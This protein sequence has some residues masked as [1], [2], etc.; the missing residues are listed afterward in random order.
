MPSPG[1][2]AAT[3]R[4]GRRHETRRPRQALS[5]AA[6]APTLRRRPPRAGG[7]RKHPA[8]ACRDEHVVLDAH[9]DPAELR[10]D[11]LVVGL[12]VQ[13]GLDRQHHALGQRTPLIRLGASVG[14]VVHVQAEHV[15]GAVQRVAPVQ[16]HVLLQRFRRRD[17]EQTPALERF[18]DDG[19]GGPVRVEEVG[20]R[21]GGVDAGLLGCQHDVVHLALHVAEVAVDRQ[22]A[23]DVRGVEAV[24]LDPH[25]EQSE[26]AGLHPAVVTDPVQR[27]RVRAGRHDRSVADVVS[28][29]PRASPEGAFDPAFAAVH[30]GGRRQLA[31][32]FGEAAT[33]HR[34]RMLEFADLE[35]VFQQPQFAARDPERCLASL[36]AARRTLRSTRESTP[37]ITRVLPGASP[38]RALVSSSNGRHVRSSA[39]A[40]SLTPRRG[41]T[42]SSP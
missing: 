22:G 36:V 30:G 5:S 34:D 8:A 28:F 29:E 41:P 31:H 15:R 16:A 11:G 38:L 3:G 13:P 24:S 26:V 14:A 18:R 19:H 40:V 10:R 35:R 6:R 2:A 32:A 7:V 9:A 33:G 20:A 1:S 25:V 17:P 4:T 37:R 23:R 21:L 12:E 27:G 42:H 39:A